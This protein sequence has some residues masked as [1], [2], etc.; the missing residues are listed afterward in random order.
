MKRKKREWEG[1]GKRKEEEEEGQSG[2]NKV[3]AIYFMNLCSH[4][5]AIF[6]SLEAS[7]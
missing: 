7:H 2:M 4:F 5:V 1:E 6:C 3:K